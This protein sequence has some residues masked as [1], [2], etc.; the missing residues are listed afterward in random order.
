MNRFSPLLALLLLCLYQIS[1]N[2]QQTDSFSKPVGIIRT[3]ANSHS[4]H[5]SSVPF[6]PFDSS[7]NG[8]FNQQLAGEST[9][10]PADTILKWDP[11]LQSFLSA[12]KADNTGD[13]NKN[14]KWFQ[15]NITWA[16]SSLS[17]ISG[18]GFYLQNKH[19]LDAAYPNYANIFFMG[20][21]VLDDNISISIYPDANMFAYPFSTKMPLNSTSLATGGAQGA[22]TESGNSDTI[23]QNIPNEKGF[24]LL[25]DQASQDDGKWHDGSSVTSFEF[26]PGRGFWYNGKI[27]SPYSWTAIR[28]YANLFSGTTPEVTAMALNAGKDEVTLTISCTGASGEV[29]EIFYQDIGD[30]SDFASDTNWKIAAENIATNSQTSVTWTDAGQA[31]NSFPVGSRAK[32]DK[33]KSRIYLVVRQDVDYDTDGLSDAREK[34]ITGTNAGLADTDSDSISDGIEFNQHTSPLIATVC[35]Y[36]DDNGS[37]GNSGLTSGAPKATINAGMELAK[38]AYDLDNTKEYA[39]LVE[40]GT[41]AGT[42]NTA[43]DFEGYNNIKLIAVDGPASTTIDC[44]ST[45]QSFI[46]S[47]VSSTTMDKVLISGFEIIDSAPA[48]A[49]SSGMVINNADG[50]VFRNCIFDSCTGGGGAVADIDASSVTFE[51]CSFTN[52]ANAGIYDGGVLNISSSAVIID[53]C[54]FTGNHS[55]RYGGAVYVKDS[56]LDPDSK[57]LVLKNSTFDINTAASHGGALYSTNA[58]LLIENTEFNGNSHDGVA[59]KYGGAAYLI[60]SSLSAVNCV[61]KL[62]VATYFGGALYITTSTADF[63]GCLFEQNQNIAAADSGGAI[64][65]LTATMSI[66]ESRFLKNTTSGHGGAI[67]GSALD[68]TVRNCEFTENTCSTAATYDGGAINML[69]VSRLKVSDSSFIGNETADSGGAIYFDG[70]GGTLESPLLPGVVL[71]AII[72]RCTFQGNKAHVT[73]GGAIRNFDQM[74]I[75]DS[76]INNNY[77]KARAGGIYNGGAGLYI[78]NSTISGNNTDPDTTSYGGGIYTSSSVNIYNSTIFG[79]TTK[80][81]GGGIYRYLGTINIYSSIIAGNTATTNPDMRGTYA[82]FNNSLVGTKGA[83]VFTDD[84][85]SIEQ[86]ISSDI[87]ALAYNGGPTKTH[88]IKSTCAAKDIGSNPLNLT[89]DQ[90]GIPYS[91]T[92]NSITDAGSFEYMKHSLTIA[93]N[94]IGTTDP[95]PGEHFYELNTAVPVEAIPG[96][97][98]HFVN[99]TV[100]GNA[101]VSDENSASA[102]VVLTGTGTVTANFSPD[103]K[104]VTFIAGNDGSLEDASQQTFETIV[105]NIPYG[106]DCEPVIANPDGGAGVHFIGWTGDATGKTNPLT[107]TNVTQ[108]MTITANFAVPDYNTVRFYPG[109]NGSINP[110]PVAPATYSEQFVQHNWPSSAVTA[111]PDTGDVFIGWSGDYTSSG[112]Y[113]VTDNPLTIASVRSDMDITANFAPATYSVTFV[114]GAN[115]SINGTLAQTVNYHDDSAS[116]TAVADTWYEFTGW[117]GDYT[118][119]PLVIPDVVS[120]MTVTA[121]FALIDSDGDGISDKEEYEKGYDKNTYTHLYYV[122]GNVTTSGDGLSLGSAKKTIAEGMLLA[123]QNDGDE[124]V[125]LVYGLPSSGVY[126]GTGNNNLD[127]DGYTFKLIA[128]EDTYDVVIDCTDN[129]GAFVINN[130]SSIDMTGTVIAG[131]TVKDGNLTAG[132]SGLLIQ[133]ASGIVVKDCIFDSCTGGAGIVV[134][135]DGSTATFENCEFKNNSTTIASIDGGVF[136]LTGS[137]IKLIDCNIHDNSATRYGGVAYVSA[138]S[139]LEITVPD[140]ENPPQG[141]TNFINNNETNNHGGAIYVTDSEL[142]IKYASFDTNKNILANNIGGAIYA[143]GSTLSIDNSVFSNNHSTEDGGAICALV[144]STLAVKNSSFTGNIADD[145]GGAIYFDGDGNGLTSSLFPTVDFDCIIERCTFSGNRAEVTYGG[146]I[147]NFHNMLI[148]DSTLDTNYGKTRA[149]GIYNALQLYLVNSTVSGNTTDE[150]VASY[151]GGIFTTNLTQIYNSTIVKN[152]VTTSGGGIYRYGGVITV[153]S[154]IFAGNETFAANPDDMKGAFATFK[155]SIIGNTV[156]ATFTDFTGSSIVADMPNQ[157]EALTDNGGPTETH[158]LKLG[159]VAIDA[160]CN[161]SENCIGLNLSYDQRG[162]EFGRV[163]GTQADVGACESKYYTLTV[164]NGTGD[165]SY[166]KGATVSIQATYDPVSHNFINWTTSDGGG[167]ADANSANTTYTMPANNATVSANTAIKTYSLQYAVNGVGGTLTGNANQTID[168]GSDGSQV[169]AVPDAGYHFINWSDDVQTASRTDLNVTADITVTANF[170]IDTFTLTYNAGAN[171]TLNAGAGNVAQFQE[172]VNF[173]TDGTSVTAVPN[174]GYHFL[175]WSDD[176]LDNPRQETEVTGDLDPPV[177]AN[178]E[179]NTYTVNFVAGPNGTIS[180]NT[181]QSVNHG[182]NSLPITVTPD[183]GYTFYCDYSYTKT[184]NPNTLTLTN[185]SSGGTVNVHFLL[186]TGDSDSDGLSDGWE[187]DNFGNLSQDGTGDYDLDDLINSVEYNNNYNPNNQDDPGLLEINVSNLVDGGTIK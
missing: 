102:N 165:G 38:D 2:A 120:I 43:L 184:T 55:T 33:V 12:F 17:L 60:N 139:K 84:T 97:G 113:P 177:T 42:G 34:F 145:S 129:S 125:V 46:L 20:K 21:M 100:S 149:G 143:T 40:D 105:Q 156:N 62:N 1:A 87:E 181:S 95:A 130:A 19:A 26:L 163:Q 128:V 7:L 64:Y 83:A 68:L 148:L 29:L 106:S 158:A 6:V 183:A 85:G 90:R 141:Q 144:A 168:H 75:A 160:G 14:G 72:E 150:N 176:I 159:S 71:D 78:V 98:Q 31:N 166:L 74:L 27:S 15:D 41:Y 109:A 117:T 107:I 185:V 186:I 108:N 99:W 11:V 136:H 135:S 126:S 56:R 89:Y 53:H 18:E 57:S 138:S 155:H 157:I 147:R 167:F 48:V 171:G 70:S 161:D 22:A 116:V 79:N 96:T 153:H 137:D 91:R 182:A 162:A 101:S 54:S 103:I 58:D 39:V 122:D 140:I 173:M 50:A 133:N 127:F 45:D 111:I 36:V 151:G 179:I 25:D 132:G 164:E 5:L 169:V 172:I 175:S 9:S 8:I 32:I 80:N 134:D 142:D 178:F 174:T 3:N 119:N 66:D 93:V 28:P 69:G 65:A 81:D 187:I 86:D 152:K 170:A 180:E 76:T 24:W 49:A 52:N 23:T 92:Y 16:L 77:A 88:A 115:G 67:A 10:S 124:H 154:S 35:Y 63:S 59:N 37:D 146:A 121:N 82:I 112:V 44:Q 47:N 94:G 73:Y 13:A 110:A 51:Y 131:F 104:T 123:K 30:W 114:A 118:E 61:F 4:R